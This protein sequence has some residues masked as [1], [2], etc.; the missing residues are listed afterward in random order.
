MVWRYLSRRSPTRCRKRSPP[1]RERL[2]SEKTLGMITEHDVGAAA[3]HFEISGRFCSAAVKGGDEINDS[4]CVVFDQAGEPVRVILQRINHKIFKNPVALMENIQRVTSHLAAQVAGEADSDRR[5]LTLIPG[6][7]GKAWHVDAHGNTWRAYRFI[8]GARFFFQPCFS[9]VWDTAIGA[10]ALAMADPRHESLTPAADWLLHKEIR[11]KGDWSVKRPNT[12]PSGWA[13][14]YS[15]EF[16]PDIDD[17][18]MVMLSLSEVRAS[19]PG[20]Q[21]AA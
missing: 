11:R 6:R 13:F 12:E 3:R 2:L 4:Y 15:N 21:Q 16:Y 8:D 18:A 5:V 10:Y 19:N 14:E 1:D 9:P 7:D 17:T 20:A